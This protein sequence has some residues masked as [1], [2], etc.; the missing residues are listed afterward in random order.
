MRKIG[1]LNALFLL[2]TLCVFSQGIWT[3]KPSIGHSD[4]VERTLAT[5]FEINGQGYIAG[6]NGVGRQNFTN[7]LNDVHRFTPA[8]NT[9]NRVA[10]C[11]I[12]GRTGSVSFSVNGKGY[13]GMGYIQTNSSTNIYLKD[14][15]EYN[16]LTNVWT[17]KA[18]MGSSGRHSP[19]SFVIGNYGFVGCGSSN[20]APLVRF[21]FWRYDPSTNTWLQKASLT[22]THARYGA[23]GFSI[24]AKGYVTCGYKS[25]LSGPSKDLMEYD[26]TANVWTIKASLPV[27]APAR[28]FANGFALNGKGYVVGGNDNG[29]SFYYS[30]C[31]EY[32]NVSDVWSQKTS[33]PF[34]LSLSASFVINNEGY[35]LTGVRNGNAIDNS[36]IKYNA[37]TN[38]W[39]Q[40]IA[41]KATARSRMCASVIN[42]KLWIGPG[43]YGDYNY[44]NVGTLFGK[45]RRDT[46]LYDPS[47]EIWTAKDSFPLNR[48][49]ASSFTV[50]S[51]L[52]L[53]GG[54]DQTQAVFN[55]CW[56]YNPNGGIWTQVANFTGPSRLGGVALTIDNRGYYGFGVAPISNYYNDW[57][58]YIPSSNSWVTKTSAPVNFAGRF[59]AGAFTI[60]GKGY[61]V[62]GSTLGSNPAQCY[63]Y[64]PLTNAWAAKA[65]LNIN[66]R[67]AGAAFAIGNKGYYACG[68]LQ[69]GYLDTAAFKKDFYEFDPIAN[70]WVEKATLPFSAGREGCVGLGTNGYGY[71]IGGMQVAQAANG[72]DEVF[73]F[74]SDMWQYTPDSIKPTIVGGVTAF[75]AGSSITVNFQSVALT[76]NAGNVFSIQLSNSSGSFSSPVTIGTLTST[77]TSGSITGTIPTGQAAG[78]GYRIRIVSSNFA[79]IGDDNGVNLTISRNTLSI[80]SFLPSSGLAGDSITITGTNFIGASKVRFNG[81]LTGYRVVSTTQI[82]AAVPAL[83][84][85]GKINIITACDSVLSS[86]N[87]LVNTF[88]FPMKLFVEGL[89][90]TNQQM[91]P[92][93]YLSNVSTDTNA[94]DTITLK[95][96]QPLAP[97]AV[98]HETKCILLKDGNS[99]CAIPGGFYNGSY[100]VEV[101]T[102]NS[103]A[104]WS[105]TAIL[106]NTA[107]LFLLA[108]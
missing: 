77:A 103:L 7:S 15:W 82:K 37:L 22:S 6:G 88:N 31:Y 78:T 27:S 13:V 64:N 70:T 35:I 4:Y 50:D 83:A 68:Y 55:T 72:L 104:T 39:T 24:G 19:F 51:I 67:N 91:V 60:N 74:K 53:V 21:D 81:I 43:V 40:L 3:Q 63:E 25:A 46:W 62:A 5:G 65:N 100:F 20:N 11:G 97:Y 85:T 76:L 33:A 102:R 2:M 1:F 95:L 57:Y 96:H 29:P 105:K 49:S 48:Y 17:Q 44:L 93:L 80:S 8:G 61:V 75:C 87:F 28:I 89:Y 45:F 10:D 99:V 107:L 36:F 84:T 16:P 52:Y 47:T 38:T 108:Q 41:P 106:I 34:T 66:T 79:D 54:S 32:D 101:K 14:L 94:C 30:D 12:S 59:N 86:T 56:S 42:D 58:E 18:D 92:A 71:V 73:T 9:W 90:T 23:V 98:V 26:T 69:T